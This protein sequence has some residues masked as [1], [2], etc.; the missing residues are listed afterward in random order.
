M[1]KHLHIFES[2][3]E[4]ILDGTYPPGMQLPPDSEFH[5]SWGVNKT[6]VIRALKDLERE[7]LIV[8]RQGSGSFVAE[9]QQTPILPG[10]KL[11]IG[12]LCRKDLN[13]D[14]LMNRFHGH[15]INGIADVLGLGDVQPDWP[16]H[17]HHQATCSAWSLPGRAVSLV[18]M[19]EALASQVRHP[20]LEE[21][22]AA[23]LDGVITV[24][25]LEQPFLDALIARGLPCVFADYSDERYA[26]QADQVFVD[27]F[28]AHRSLIRYL[29]EKGLRRIHFVGGFVSIPAPSPAMTREEVA[30]F[31][32]GR[33]AI[34]PD[35]LMRMSAWRH[36][37][38]ECGLASPERWA[39]FE[40]P[41]LVK[42][43]ELARRLL[44][45]PADE[46]PEAVI[47]HS[48]TQA[49]RLMRCFS[50]KGIRLVGAGV[51]DSGYGGAALPIRA[52]GRELGTA[53]AELLISRIQRPKRLQ[54]RVGVP[55]IFMPPAGQGAGT[56]STAAQ[57]QS[58]QGR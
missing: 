1:A 41:W 8:R 53:A 51:T 33:M 57:P 39:H 49:E 12:V 21:V 40:N 15:I 11:R 52:Y 25:I 29:S 54:L 58:L 56:Q 27:P 31:R 9:R 17:G 26:L 13:P 20:P 14:A 16:A 36:G 48:V 47:C 28:P 18:A 44:E 55:M 38:L 4:R 23:G 5:K 2:V 7:G 6:T 35:S 32:Q 19:G 30:E 42:D 24:S 37:M 43:E 34:D 45:L 46:G 22:D 3:R 10:R 50:E